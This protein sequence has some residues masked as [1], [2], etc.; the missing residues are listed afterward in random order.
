ML[1]TALG[2]AVDSDAGTKDIA[3]VWRI[4]GTAN[5]PNAEKVNERGRPRAPQP[6]KVATP[7]T[8][9]LVEPETLQAAIAEHVHANGKANGH[10]HTG[11]DW[12]LLFTALPA[13]LK[14]LITSPPLPDEDRSAVAASV[15]LSLI[16]R[17]WSDAKISAVI[18]AHPLGIG[19][20]Y[21][22]GSDLEAD[23]K[24]LRKKSEE[25]GDQKRKS[26]PKL[27]LD[28]DPV[29]VAK[30]L[31]ALIASRRDILLNGHTPVRVV[32]E[33]GQDPRAVEL[34]PEAVRA[35]AYDICRCIKTGKNKDSVET[36]LKQDIAKLYLHGLE[37]EWGLRPLRGIS[38]SPLLASDGSIRSASGYDEATGLWCHTIPAV[39]VPAQPTKDDAQKALLVLRHAFSTFP[40]GDADNVGHLPQLDESTHL[41]AL[42]TSTCRACLSLAPGFLY[43][44]PSISGAGTGK[45]LLAK[46]AC[47]VGSGV[48]P[49]AMTVGH[50]V[51]ELDKRLVA[52]AIEAR[53]AIYLDNFNEGMLDSHTLASFLTED[54]ARVRVLG[55]SKTMP[56]NTR[57]MVVITGNAVQIAEDMARRILQVMLD[58]RMENPEQRSFAPGFLQSVFARRGKLL[59]EC[60]TIWRWGVQQG[61]ALPRGRPIGSYE[62]W[63]RWCRDPLL[64]LGC[65]DPIERL[66]DIKAADP[67]RR[68][69]IEVFTLWDRHHSDQPVT[70]TD[71]HLAVKEAI[72]PDAKRNGDVVYYNRQRVAG[73]LRKHTDTRAGGFHLRAEVPAINAQRNT[74][75]RYRLLRGPAL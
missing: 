8:G 13:S 51:E 31:A 71:L 12:Q 40:F 6:V 26:L 50:S 21:A 33:Q 65:R 36:P 27:D 28:A 10:D 58:A 3:H 70:T 7:W 55:H 45:G 24:R 57:A 18:E 73:F 43:N 14:K 69:L 46:S 2:E 19:A 38:T 30:A 61:D 9:E 16:G 34:T 20:R 11:G 22:E 56:L 52:A 17:G 74:V 47:V 67:K 49:S 68:Q 60:L 35:Y 59:S 37:G 1:A 15:I 25:R 4:G 44:A 62:Q 54:P 63:A 72:D 23:I 39:S 41:I 5:W 66:A 32:I 75:A 48:Q 42:M 64:A 53:P 29:A